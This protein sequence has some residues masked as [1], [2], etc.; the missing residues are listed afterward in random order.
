MLRRS[1]PDRASEGE[2]GHQVL[3]LLQPAPV[4]RW[5]H[6][7]RLH[8]IRAGGSQKPQGYRRSGLRRAPGRPRSQSRT[9]R[10]TKSAL[11]VTPQC[12]TSH[13]R[14]PPCAKLTTEAMGGH[15]R[16]FAQLFRTVRCRTD[17]CSGAYWYMQFFFYTMS[18]TRMGRYKFFSWTLH[19]GPH[20]HLQHAVGIALKDWG[21]DQNT[22]SIQPVSAG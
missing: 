11:P 8:G 20:H 6:K 1:C 19:Y 3:P 10:R 22:F 9:L 15:F 14:L 16:A 5:L 12:D 17:E 18:E 21:Q 4:S 7:P 2:R 13:T